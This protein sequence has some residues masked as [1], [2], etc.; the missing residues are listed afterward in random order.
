MNGDVIEEDDDEEDEEP[1]GVD[2]EDAKN[3]APA[4]IA[5]EVLYDLVDLVVDS[6]ITSRIEN[7]LMAEPIDD[8][9]ETSQ[10]NHS[11]NATEVSISKRLT[12]YAKQM[13]ERF[14]STDQPLSRLFS[15]KKSMFIRNYVD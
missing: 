13:E 10:E 5:K 4:Q 7:G 8:E 6:I 1:E 9:T 15:V 14:N 3:V 12:S 2:T 11:R